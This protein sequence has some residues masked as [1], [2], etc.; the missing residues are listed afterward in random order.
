MLVPPLPLNKIRNIK[1]TRK[2]LEEYNEKLLCPA[3]PY[4]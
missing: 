2:K 4:D 1:N 3:T